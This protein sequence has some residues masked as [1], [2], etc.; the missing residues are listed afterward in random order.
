MRQQPWQIEIHERFDYKRFLKELKTEHALAV[1]VFLFEV[2]QISDL[3]LAPRSWIKPLKAGLFEFR[4]SSSGSLIRIFFT[5]KRGRVIFLL[6]AYDKGG[7]SST[8]RQQ[9]EIL[10]ARSRMI[11]A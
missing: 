5:F 7:D 10:V 2:A 11:N 1:S 8:K 9:R 3:K 6:G 4:I